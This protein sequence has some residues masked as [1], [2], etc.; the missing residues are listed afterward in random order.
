MIRSESVCVGDASVS[1]VTAIR[2]LGVYINAVKTQVTNT[3]RA[4]FAALRQISSVRW[5]LPQHA[6]LT[7]VQ[8]LVIIKLDQCNSVLVGTSGYLQV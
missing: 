7:L 6:L 2:D 5:A 4:C 3:V 1:P 8:A